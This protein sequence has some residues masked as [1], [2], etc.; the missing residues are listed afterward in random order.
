MIANFPSAWC[1]HLNEK[2]HCKTSKT[3]KV[4]NGDL[5]GTYHV[6]GFIKIF[7]V[8]EEQDKAD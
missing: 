8:G 1:Y 7:G 4:Q 5:K 3:M 6:V 2:C